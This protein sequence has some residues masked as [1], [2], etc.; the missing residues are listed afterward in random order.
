MKNPTI[1][2]KES[3][4]CFGDKCMQKEE[5]I[6]KL[7][8]SPYKVLEKTLGIKIRNGQTAEGIRKALKWV[9]KKK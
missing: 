5:D 3:V 6:K 4:A 9:L 2:N 8:N 1:N 7:L